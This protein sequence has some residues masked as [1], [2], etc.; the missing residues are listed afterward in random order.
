MAIEKV[1]L[2][3]TLVGSTRALKGGARG[4][5]NVNI[6]GAKWGEHAGFFTL[7][8]PAYSWTTRD[9]VVVGVCVL[10]VC[11]LPG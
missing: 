1:C 6:L 11:V 5:L 7:D 4:G 8:L 3:R 10:Y 2:A 9:G